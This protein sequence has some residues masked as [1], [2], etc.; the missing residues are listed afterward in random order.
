MTGSA[1]AARPAATRCP[2]SRFSKMRQVTASCV[3]HHPT[4]PYSTSA[5]PPTG[6]GK[7]GG[8]GRQSY[9]FT[10]CRR[11]QNPDGLQLSLINGRPILR[12]EKCNYFYSPIEAEAMKAEEPEQQKEEELFSAMTSTPKELNGILDEY[13]IEQQRAKRVL[14]VAVYNHYKRVHSNLAAAVTAEAGGSETANSRAS[15][16]QFDKSNIMILG[17]TGCGKTLLA[18]TIAKTLN[19]P[20]AIADCTVLTQAGYVGE[21][22]E[23][24][25]FKLLQNCDFNVEAA[26]RGIVFLDE[27]DKIG[28]SRASDGTRTRDVSGEGVQQSL[29]KL[30]EGTV[31]NVPEKG[32][33]KNPRGEFTKVDTTNILFIASGAFNGLEKVVKQRQTTSSIGFG[34]EI[35]EPERDNE[36]A[37]LLNVEPD[38]LVQFGL[39]PE[40]VGRLPVVVA[41]EELDEDAL[42]RVIKEPKNSL[43]DQYTELFNIDNTELHFGEE[44]LRAIARQA[45]AKKTGARG[46]RAI[47]ERILLE[48]M[49]EVPGSDISEVHISEAVV[50]GTSEPTYVE[51]HASDDGDGDDDDEPLSSV[52]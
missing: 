29:L 14:S 50:E 21:D 5:T 7:D 6:G 45:L 42:V 37:R 16:V 52:N 20:F 36:K 22:V 2:G 40:F 9:S 11:C 1:V 43:L 32:G 46:L 12:C 44:A 23:S 17:P 49:Y 27:I 41:V 47:F 30:L 4:M 3:G 51:G 39:I 35:A 28:S 26:E 18:Q 38:D 34:A 25:L 24:V 15:D 33:R 48:P 31:V 19:V 13:V 10:P 8:N